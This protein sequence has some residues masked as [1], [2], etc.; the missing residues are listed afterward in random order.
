MIIGRHLSRRPVRSAVPRNGF[1]L[2]EMLTTLAVGSIMLAIIG[3]LVGGF[4]IGARQADAH[5]AGSATPKTVIR[6]R[7]ML[8]DARFL[9][10]KGKLFPH[11]DR[12]VGFLYR[13]TGQQG[14]YWQYATLFIRRDAKGEQLWIQDRG[15][16]TAT[17]ILSDLKYIR[18]D[19]PVKASEAVAAAIAAIAGVDEAD[20][21]IISPIAGAADDAAAN[22]SG[23]ESAEGS[24]APEAVNQQLSGPVEILMGL[25]DG[26][27]LAI[28]M[29]IRRLA[30]LI[31]GKAPITAEESAAAA[32]EAA[33]T[34][35]PGATRR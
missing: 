8:R 26:Q 32:G 31:V 14:S 23:S 16:P 29:D 11:D 35:L 4:A 10:E 34:A 20:A 19:F 24:P 17:M 7:N 3:N 9:D 5:V 21:E 12:S 28:R 18:F 30:P 15:A 33:G 22:A 6:L 13:R 1:T 27:E 25:Q 2:L